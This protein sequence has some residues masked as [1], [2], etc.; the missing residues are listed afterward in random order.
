MSAGD[1][2]QSG[3]EERDRQHLG[4]DGAYSWLS[5]TIAA[6]AS[7]GFSR[8][9][10]YLSTHSSFRCF[11]VVERTLLLETK[12]Y[13]ANTHLRIMPSGA[14]L[15]PK[16]HSAGDPLP[17][18]VTEECTSILPVDKVASTSKSLPVFL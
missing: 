16:A 10:S 7:S 15:I 3:G 13:E 14:S 11:H 2:R 4:A 17:S 9:P 1:D 5:L 6:L 18:L 8:M 12:E